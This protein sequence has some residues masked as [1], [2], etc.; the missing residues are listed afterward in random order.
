MQLQGHLDKEISKSDMAK[1]VGAYKTLNEVL[2]RTNAEFM[3]SLKRMLTEKEAQHEEL[4]NKLDKNEGTES[5]NAQYIF[6]G[7]YIQCLKDILY[8]KQRQV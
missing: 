2:V 1:K 5:E 3:S 6:I 8:A 4:K 7:G